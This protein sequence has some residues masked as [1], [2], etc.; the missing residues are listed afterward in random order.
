MNTTSSVKP[1][2]AAGI[3][4]RP[5]TE[6][7]LGTFLQTMSVPYGFDPTPERLDRFRYAFELSR[8]RA[9][10]DARQMVATFGSLDLTLTIP[11]GMLS[12]SGVTVVSVLPTHRRRGVLR[13]MMT[14]HL[15]EVHENGEALA[16]LWASESS[17]YGRFGYGPA[18]QRALMKLEKP[19]ARLS[20]LGRGQ[21]DSHGDVRLVEVDEALQVFPAIYDQVARQRPG[22]FRRSPDWW[23]HRFLADL[24]FFR[25]GAT[26]HRRAL[27]VRQGQPAGY[28]VFR[29]KSDSTARPGELRVVELVG[30]DGDSQRALWQFLFGVDL[31]ESLTYWNQPID[32]PLLWWVEEPRRIQ[33]RIE[34]ALWVRTVDV[35]RASTPGGTRPAAASYCAC[36]IR[37]AR[38]TTASFS[39]RPTTTAPLPA[40]RPA[41]P[42]RSS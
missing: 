3:V 22:M 28:V 5:L 20:S 35:P 21:G 6:D 9:A 36:E 38:G 27:Y 4:V 17:I 37:S 40:N 30:V 8:L 2:P 1:D 14:Q 15:A 19:F 33:R 12:A 24:E 10:F 41:Q 42:P 25:D 18:S 13:A 31:I 34:D 32:D 39:W 16:V 29:T 7:E 26:V 11:G 23:Q